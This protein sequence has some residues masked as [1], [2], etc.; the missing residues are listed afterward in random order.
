MAIHRLGI[1]ATISLLALV[2]S[3]PLPSIAL[4]QTEQSQAV[5]PFPTAGF[6]SGMIDEVERSSIRI[7][8]R[9]YVL[10]FPP[11]WW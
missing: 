3:G 1:F 7:D 2:Q 6:Q 11:C 9:S 5:M 8:G 10:K 4:A